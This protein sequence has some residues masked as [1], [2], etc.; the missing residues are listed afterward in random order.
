MHHNQGTRILCKLTLLQAKRITCIYLYPERKERNDKVYE[1]MWTLRM[2]MPVMLTV[3]IVMRRQLML[4]IGV[5][6][7]GPGRRIM[8]IT[9]AT[10]M[11]IDA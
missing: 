3:R 11:R 5:I 4:R 7:N 1:M 6:G 8:V 9:T 10:H 2:V